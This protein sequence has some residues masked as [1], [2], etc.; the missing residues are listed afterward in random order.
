[1]DAEEKK[2]LE[3]YLAL[4]VFEHDFEMASQGLALFKEY[5]SQSRLAYPLFRDVIIAYI[6]P[7]KKSKGRYK[8]HHKIQGDKYVPSHM[9]ALHKELETYRDSVFAHTDRR[10]PPN[11][12]H[13]KM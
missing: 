13:L 3:G 4:R 2:W 8:P 11:L 6:R 7:F 9:Q 12:V 5:E 10:D 1:M